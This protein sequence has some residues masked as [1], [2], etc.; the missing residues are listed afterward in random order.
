M[1]KDNLP[2]EITYTKLRA[3]IAYHLRMKELG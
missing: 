1:L 3:V 2:A